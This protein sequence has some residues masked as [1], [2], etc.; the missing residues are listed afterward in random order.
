MPLAIDLRDAA[1]D[2]SEAEQ[3]AELMQANPRL[4]SLD[5]RNNEGMGLDGAKALGAF[6]EGLG[7]GVTHVPRSLCGVTPA[8]SV[9]EVPKAPGA[10]ELRILCAPR[11]HLHLLLLLT[12]PCC[13][14]S[15]A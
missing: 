3:L 12:S 15:P 4:T 5:V 14:P 8:N 2:T 9:L 13:M 1:I 7:R 10:V 11:L 6:M